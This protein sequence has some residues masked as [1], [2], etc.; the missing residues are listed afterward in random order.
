VSTGDRATSI[1]R[2]RFLGLSEFGP[3]NVI[4]HE[5]RK[6]RV[7]GVVVPASGLEARLTRAKLCQACGYVHSGSDALAVDLC[8]HCGIL[9]DGAT[10]DFPQALLDQPTVRTSRWARITSDEEERVREGYNITTHYHFSP[11]Y[12]YVRRTAKEHNDHTL[13]EVVYAPQAD[14]WRIN[15]GWRNSKGGAGFTIDLESGRWRGRED[16]PIDSG[17]EGPAISAT[18]ARSGIRTYIRDNRNLLLLQPTWKTDDPQ[19]F[20]ARA[21]ATCRA[22]LARSTI[23]V[24]WRP[25]FSCARQPMF[26]TDTRHPCG[27]CRI[28]KCR[29]FQSHSRQSGDS[30]ITVTRSRNSLRNRRQLRG[31]GRFQRV[32]VSAGYEGRRSVPSTITS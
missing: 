5:G 9:L 12:N 6:H 29:P 17:D 18:T 8:A 24:R 27:I 28:W 22:S 31:H 26:A 30:R 15:H 3:W 20:F 11:D 25:P 23:T 2:S 19:R 13:M 10:S 7:V 1:E 14:L 16:D 4:Y 21:R 32:P